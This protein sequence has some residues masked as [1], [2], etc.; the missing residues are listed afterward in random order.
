MNTIRIS[1]VASVALLLTACSDRVPPVEDPVP[2][3]IVV[4]N[5][6]FTQQQF[7]DKYCN[8]KTQDETCLKVRRAMV[9]GSTR[10]NGAPVRF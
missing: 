5:E 6:T 7:I 2:K 3:Q 4:G 10:S 8:D 1:V 9:A